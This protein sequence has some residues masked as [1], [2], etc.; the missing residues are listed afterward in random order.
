MGLAAAWL[1]LLG[2]TNLIALGVTTVEVIMKKIN[3]KN[4]KSVIDDMLNVG[5]TLFRF[6]KAM[7]DYFIGSFN[8]S[9]NS[10]VRVSIFCTTWSSLDTNT[11]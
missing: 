3:N 5:L 2:R 7:G 10:M 8:K 9:I 1:L 6:F 11:L 4:T